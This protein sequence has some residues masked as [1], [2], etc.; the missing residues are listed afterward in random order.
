MAFAIV[1]GPTN[2]TL[3]GT[4]PNVTYT[5]KA[6]YNGPDSFTFKV[7]DSV[8]NTSPATISVTVTAVNDAPV[9]DAQVVTTA[10]NT[11]VP[12]KLTGSRC[13]WEQPDLRDCDWTNEWRSK[14]YSA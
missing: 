13:G 14:W 9:A 5:P 12:I 4:A 1:S 11:A 7:F 10:E 3:S 8:L 6:N 2:G